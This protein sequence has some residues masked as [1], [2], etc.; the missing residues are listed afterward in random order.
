MSLEDEL[1]E[2]WND[3]IAAYLWPQMYE[4]N[5]ENPKSISNFGPKFEPGSSKYRVEALSTNYLI[6]DE[7]NSAFSFDTTRI[8]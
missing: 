2:I 7:I 5:D 3:M 6:L 4:K 8:L 1:I